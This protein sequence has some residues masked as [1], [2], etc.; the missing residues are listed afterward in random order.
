MVRNAVRWTILLA[1]LLLATL[2]LNS[3]LFSAWIAGGPPNP[4]P[5]AWAHRAVTQSCT[6]ASLVLAGIAS[7]RVIRTFPRVGILP[8]LTGLVAILVLSVPKLRE[9]VLIDS[10]LDSGGRWEAREFRCNGRGLSANEQSWHHRATRLR[11]CRQV[12]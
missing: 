7:F 12:K 9:F 1:T 6:A 3:A 2:Y 8:L 10:C 11:R 5:D 4:I